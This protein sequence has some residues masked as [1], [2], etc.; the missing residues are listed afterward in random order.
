MT[1]TKSKSSKTV[2]CPFCSH[3]TSKVTHTEH[4]STIRNG[5]V[6]WAIKRRR[7]CGKCHLSFVTKE[8][9]VEDTS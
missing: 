7:K 5:R 1:K 2:T 9:V 4:E 8:D 3:E 6:N